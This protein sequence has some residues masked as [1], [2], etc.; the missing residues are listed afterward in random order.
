MNYPSLPASPRVPLHLILACILISE[1]EP[2]QVPIGPTPAEN[3]VVVPPEYVG[4]RTAWP[5]LAQVC[6]NST[7]STSQFLFTV[8]PGTPTFIRSFALRRGDVSSTPQ[9]DTPAFSVTV[10]CWMGHSSRDPSRISYF[11]GDNRTADFRAI[12]AQRAFSF[13]SVQWRSDGRYDFAYRFALDQPFPFRPGAV[14]VIEMRVISSTLCTNLV[15]RDLCQVEYYTPIS[16]PG[17]GDNSVALVGQSCPPVG[18]TSPVITLNSLSGRLAAGGPEAR[19][20]WTT[21]NWY[22][23]SLTRFLVGLGGIPWGGATLPF[24]LDQMG[25]PGCV[26]YA[27]PLLEARQFSAG[28]FY[29]GVL[30]LPADPS[31]VGASAFVQG[32]R[33]DG[34]FNPLGLITSNAVRYTVLSHID[35]LVSSCSWNSGPSVTPMADTLGLQGPVMLLDGR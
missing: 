30:A 11:Y 10:E 24:A 17:Y 25:A 12:V 14:G 1:L 20:L 4:N 2:A 27:A 5:L 16:P 21:N 32:V 9:Q 28:S 35:S 31:I 7:P 26:L 23:Q 29:F 3:L 18:G 33:L 15:N 6:P 8:P 19:V 13:P 34:R 22:R